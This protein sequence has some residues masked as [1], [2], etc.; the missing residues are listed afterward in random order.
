M[1]LLSQTN[2]KYV[3]FIY[4]THPMHNAYRAILSAVL[5]ILSA[6]ESVVVATVLG[7]VCKQQFSKNCEV[8]SAV[9]KSSFALCAVENSNFM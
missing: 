7:Q 3:S 5:Q 4:C 2:F 9:E 1:S 8:L 6:T